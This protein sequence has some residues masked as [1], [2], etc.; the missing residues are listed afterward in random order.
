MLENEQIQ[1]SSSLARLSVK[2]W[3]TLDETGSKPNYSEPGGVNTD[4]EPDF[5][6]LPTFPLCE[7]FNQQPKEYTEILPLIISER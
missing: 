2:N 4:Q 3:A 5:V 1:Y 6:S 7:L